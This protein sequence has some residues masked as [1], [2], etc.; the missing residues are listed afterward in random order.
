MAL[1]PKQARTAL[2][3]LRAAIGAGAWLAPEKTAR[4]FGISLDENIAGPFLGRLFGARDIAMA[5][6][7]S[8]AEPTEQRRQLRVGIVVDSLDA[9]AAII[10]G[11]KG[12]L[13]RRSAAMAASVALVAAG[14]G[15]MAQMGQA[16]V[17]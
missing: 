14:L 10:A 1:S 6:M 16:E 4:L 17:E 7:V 2:I 15:V 12:R 11:T 13:T 8:A 5:L 3:G 9:T